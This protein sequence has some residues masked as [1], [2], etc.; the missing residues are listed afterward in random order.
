MHELAVI[1]SRGLFGSEICKFYIPTHVY[2]SNNIDQLSLYDYHTVICAAPSANR[3]TAQ[4]DPGAD[5]ASVDQI[6]AS[7]RPNAYNVWC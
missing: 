6:I 2:N 3:R 7:L 1:G 5:A 4:A